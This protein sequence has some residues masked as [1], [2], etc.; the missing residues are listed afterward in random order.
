MQVRGLIRGFSDTTVPDYE[1][2]FRYCFNAWHL[3]E[4]RNQTCTV[5]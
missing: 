5:V 4:C 2:V 1:T 3:D